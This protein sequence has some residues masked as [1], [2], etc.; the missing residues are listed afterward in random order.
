MPIAAEE[1]ASNEKFLAAILRCA[2]EL[3]AIYNESPRIASIFAAQQR[4]LMAHTGFA[5]HYGFPGDARTGLYAA[6]F[7][8]SVVTH[9]IAS[10]NTAV[11]FVQ[12]MLAYRFLEPMQDLPDRRTR[13]LTPTDYATEHLARW[14]NTHLFILDMLDGGDRADSLQA[15]I[16]IIADLQPRIATAILTSSAIRNPGPTFNLFNWANSGGVVMD[17]LISR[18]EALDPSMERIAIGRISMKDIR[19]QF[20]ISNTHLKRLLKQAAQMGS[21]GWEGTPGRS[22]FWLSRGFVSEYW[23]YQAA[24]FA[25]VDAAYEAAVNPPHRHKA[26]LASG[27]ETSPPQFTSADP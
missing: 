4:W 10:R 7:V 23:N 26:E 24:K 12:E 27:T 9:R 13:L 16:D 25:V 3:I 11:A 14:I 6:R 15:N 8:D 2:H 17:Y 18:I 5:L 21:V 19:D 1:L 20:M 22:S